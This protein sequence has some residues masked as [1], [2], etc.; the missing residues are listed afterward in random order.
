MVSFSKKCLILLCSM[1]LVDA[2]AQTVKL[3]FTASQGMGEPAGEIQITE[4]KHGLLFTP[5]V[6]GVSTGLHGFHIHEKPDCS[7][8]GMAAGGHFDLAKTGKH[9]GPYQ[10]NGHLGD[11]PALYAAVDGMVSLP[12][13]AP[14]VMHLSEI[15]NH[16]LMI[17]AGGDNYSDS[18]QPLGGGGGRMICG[19]IE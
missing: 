16:A 14:R 5:N 15:K 3:N 17:H 4:T 11:L 12:V 18:P 9:L 6:H 10:D 2:Y 7:N 13:L 19:V 1:S 8:M